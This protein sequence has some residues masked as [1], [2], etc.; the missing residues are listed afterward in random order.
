MQESEKWKWSRSVV[1]DSSRPHGLQPTR[2]LHPWDFPGKSTGVG[3]HCLLPCF[4]YAQPILRAPL[5]HSIPCDSHLL[6]LLFQ[7]LCPGC[8][9]SA[10]GIVLSYQ[11]EPVGLER[12]Y[13]MLSSSAMATA[14]PD[15]QSVHWWQSFSN[16]SG[17]KNHPSAYLK[18][19]IS[20][21]SFRDVVMAGLG[22]AYLETVF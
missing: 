8:K 13:S 14:S 2:L 4:V 6:P 5:S 7:E 12:R 10:G 16:F 22:P 20:G 17:W 15:F 21:C 19:V 3:C 9:I 18:H 11:R 1:Y